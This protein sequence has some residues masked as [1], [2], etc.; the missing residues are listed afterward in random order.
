MHVERSMH[1][2]Q[3]TRTIDAGHRKGSGQRTTKHECVQ[4]NGPVSERK[5]RKEGKGKCG[6]LEAVNSK[7]SEHPRMSM[8]KKALPTRERGHVSRPTRCL[9]CPTALVP[10]GA[11]TRCAISRDLS[12]AGNLHRAT[13]VKPASSFPH[14]AAH[15]SDPLRVTERGSRSRVAAHRSLPSRGIPVTISKANVTQRPGSMGFLASRRS[16]V[17]STLAFGRWNGNCTRPF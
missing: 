16:D 7:W 10:R 12:K 17:R 3:S 9:F 13:M 15:Q 1:P 5:G 11:L 14:F 2:C 4:R 8:T 6:E